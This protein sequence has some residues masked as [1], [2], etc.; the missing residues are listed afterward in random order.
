MCYKWQV[1]S[2][3]NHQSGT[4]SEGEAQKGAM[5]AVTESQR[6]ALASRPRGARNDPRAH[7]TRRSLPCA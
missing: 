7:G 3:L 4:T 2:T 5:R 6:D 1:A